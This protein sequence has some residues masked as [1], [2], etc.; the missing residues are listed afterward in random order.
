[1]AYM[2]VADERLETAGEFKSTSMSSIGNKDMCFQPEIGC[3]IPTVSTG[4]ITPHSCAVTLQQ[5]TAEVKRLCVGSV[6]RGKKEVR[7]DYILL[8]V[9]VTVG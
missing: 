3:L 5:A 7:G 9:F 8:T 4:K 1:M 6:L 2:N